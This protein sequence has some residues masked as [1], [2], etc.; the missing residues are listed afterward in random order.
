MV[1]EDFKYKR[2]TEHPSENVLD[3]S[4][5]KKKLDERDIFYITEEPNNI[6]VNFFDI[7]LKYKK[8]KLTFLFK[9]LFH[10]Y[11]KSNYNE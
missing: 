3:V 7:E 2:V 8:C 5:T 10:K 6:F 4:Y 9:S 1:T 11:F